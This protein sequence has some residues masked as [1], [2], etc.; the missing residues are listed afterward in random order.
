MRQFLALCVVGYVLTTANPII[1]EPARSANDAVATDRAGKLYDEGLALYEAKRYAEAEA[2]YIAAWSLK[3]HYQI[4]GNL[5]DCS[6]QLGKYRD[7]AEHLTYYLREYPK[8]QP[9]DNANRARALLEEAKRHIATLD[10]VVDAAGMDVFIDGKVIGQSP[11]AGPVFVEPGQR[12]IEV[13]SGWAPTLQTVNVRA[14]SMHTVRLTS[15]APMPRAVPSSPVDWKVVAGGALGGAG[16]AVGI[17]LLMKAASV[18]TEAADL[19]RQNGIVRGTEC[20]DNPSDVCRGL[21]E[22]AR[23][24]IPYSA[25]G[26]G[27]AILGAG[28]MGFAT[29]YFLRSRGKATAPRIGVGVLSGPGLQI[30][31]SF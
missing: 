14:G 25:I 31:G 28:G 11:L 17:G 29:Y 23:Q 27:T 8:D 24:Q 12:L 20:Y 2:R 30:H 22:I 26:L 21:G 4:A 10:I 3:K 7:A 13:L 19:R 6:M 1:A 18:D 15:T 16:L 9:A 5:G